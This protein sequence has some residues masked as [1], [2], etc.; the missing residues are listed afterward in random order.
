[1]PASSRLSAQA[2][3]IAMAFVLGLLLMLARPAGHTHAADPAGALPSWQGPARAQLLDFVFAVSTPGD[4]D[5]I[6]ARDRLAVFDMDGTLM[7]ERPHFF[8]LEVALRYLE[9]HCDTLAQRGSDYTALCQAAR[10]RDMTYLRRHIEDLFSLPFEGMTFPAFRDYCRQVFEDT[11]NPV[12]ERPVREMVY[13]PMIELI[14][15]LHARGFSVWVVSGSMQFYIMAISESYFH[16]DQSRCIGTTVVGRAAK[17]DGRVVI[18]RGPSDP[19]ANLDQEKAVRI[20]LRTGRVPVL[21]FGNSEGD[22]WMLDFTASSP[23]RHLAA[24]IDHDDPREFV[25][26]KKELVAKARQADWLV[27]SMRND[28]KTIYGPAGGQP[29]GRAAQGMP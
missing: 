19:P 16:V 7:S 27:V 6:P 22:A 25:Y 29:P 11:V 23:Y 2:R 15:L 8:A 1:M 17:E 3:R 26:G 13:R 28:F 18:R 24:L 20:L 9:S 4:P 5:F 14:D 12:K 10:K 21:A